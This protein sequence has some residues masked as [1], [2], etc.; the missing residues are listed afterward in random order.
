MK[1]L[2]F[3]FK[4]ITLY[5]LITGSAELTAQSLE[6]IKTSFDGERVTITYDLN[7]TEPNQKFRINIFSSHNGYSTPI[8]SVSGDW[9]TEVA[10]GKPKK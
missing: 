5:L 4:K 6:N 2:L 7:N 8:V 10:V 1:R 9:G 3:L